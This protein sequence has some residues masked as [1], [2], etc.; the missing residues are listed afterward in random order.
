MK[1]G[2]LLLSILLA[3]GVSI[4]QAQVDDP[5]MSSDQVNDPGMPTNTESENFSEEELNNDNLEESSEGLTE[6]EREEK[7]LNDLMLTSGSNLSAKAIEE[8]STLQEERALLEARISTAES[9]QRY[10][11][12]E[13]AIKEMGGATGSDI[14]IPSM[15]NSYGTNGVI[16]AVIEYNNESYEVSRGTFID[17]N[18]VVKE[19]KKDSVEFINIDDERTMHIGINSPSVIK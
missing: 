6:S 16:K 11:E 12:I 4:A 17:K 18:W 10:I 1:K 19:V 15:V 13:E 3:S 8:I 9:K 7:T 2:I 14:E 5:G